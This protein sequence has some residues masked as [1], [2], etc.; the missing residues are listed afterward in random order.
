[1]TTNSSR[2][3]GLLAATL[4]AVTITLVLAAGSAGAAQNNG[5][6]DA[7]DTVCVWS[8]PHDYF[9]KIDGHYYHCKTENPVGTYGCVPDRLVTT[10]PQ[11][12]GSAGA[13]QKAK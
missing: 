1:M 11:A 2:E 4:S 9:C 8:S 5:G 6:G 12:H 3:L 13:T 7:S 10:R